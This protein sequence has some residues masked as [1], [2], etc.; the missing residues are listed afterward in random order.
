MIVCR[1]FVIT[2]SNSQLAILLT[3]ACAFYIITFLIRDEVIRFGFLGLV[4]HFANLLRM[5]EVTT[6]ARW[7]SLTAYIASKQFPSRCSS[8]GVT[9]ERFA[10]NWDL[11]NFALLASRLTRTNQGHAVKCEKCH[12]HPASS[13][14]NLKKKIN[15]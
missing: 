3:S 10:K 1:S 9:T 7:I 5:F 15:K 8:I 12:R 6:H 11:I 13:R 14:P 2:L 4:I